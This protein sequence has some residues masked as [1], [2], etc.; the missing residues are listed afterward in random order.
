MFMQIAQCLCSCS[1]IQCSMAPRGQ[2]GKIPSAK[3]QLNQARLDDGTDSLTRCAFDLCDKPAMLKP[4]ELTPIAWLAKS[5]E[6]SVPILVILE[7]PAGA[8][9]MERYHFEITPEYIELL[10]NVFDSKDQFGVL[11]SSTTDLET[12]TK[13]ARLLSSIFCC[14]ISPGGF[15]LT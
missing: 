6:H 11:G 4:K 5:L 2:G 10:R 3:R 14:H 12:L 9:S 1:D 15:D 8:S 13:Q 7:S